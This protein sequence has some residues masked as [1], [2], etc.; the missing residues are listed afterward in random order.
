MFLNVLSK[1]LKIGF[2]NKMNVFWTLMFPVILGTLFYIGFGS[3]FD[4][5][6]SE[7][8][9]TAVVFETED[10]AVR[11]SITESLSSLESNGTK[12]LDITVKAEDESI[13]LLDD[14]EV[15]GIITVSEDGRLSL[16]AKTNGNQTSVQET[17]VTAYNQNRDLIEKVAA[18]HPDRLQ[19]VLAGVSDR[20]SYINGKDMAGDNK[21][22]YV[23]Y[24]Y[25]LIVMT[26]LFAALNSIRI[27]HNCQ[28]NMS[29]IGARTN[30]SPMKR[31]VFQA[32]SLVAAYIVQTLIIFVALAYLLF[33]L[34]IR[35]GGNTLLIFATT[36]LASLLG[37]ALGFFVGNIGSFA[38]SK[39]ESIITA[40]TLGCCALSGLMIGDIKMDIEK[41]VPI[42][43]RINPAAVMS[44]AYVNL[45][46]FGPGRRYLVCIAYMA[47]LSA[48]FIILGLALGRRNS[49]DSI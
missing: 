23:S 27:G 6:A 33:G 14:E 2:R 40:I 1:Q 34:K 26:A 7:S 4:S 32:G 47:V 21:D 45:N 24:F 15:N 31:S 18:D 49:Y 48:V 25:N 22:P 42:I 44:D 13:K 16:K 8:I 17:I 19:D 9:K 36:A 35:F 39:K 5:Y 12:L 3:I 20:V 11:S 37:V 29:A 30:A 28:A 41:S 10:E 43:N 38:L 46:I